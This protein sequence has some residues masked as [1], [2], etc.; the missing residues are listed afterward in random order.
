M[1]FNSLTFALFFAVVLLLH[2]T[3]RNWTA[4]KVV[5]LAASYLFYAAWN[6]PFVALLMLSTVV[7]W[8]AAREMAKAP[9][10]ARRKAWL[11]L[12]LS[13]NLGL[14]GFFKYGPFLLQ[15]FAALVRS[16]GVEYVPP[17]SGII[18]PLGISFYT[19]E[20]LSYTIDVYRRQLKPNC[21]LLDFG[22]F[23]GF[24][25]HLVAGPIVRA[26]DFLPQL[27]RERRVSP[28][29]LGWGLFLMTLGLFEKNV[30]ADAL[31]SDAADA[32][33]GAPG[34]ASQLDTWVGVIAF[35]GQNLLR[36]R[37][38]HDVRDWRRVVPRLLVD[39]QLSRTVCRGWVS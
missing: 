8:F 36:L 18:L 14:L 32:V 28:N 4:K 27:E 12:S 3:L 39:R 16:F 23:V 22:L 10:D 2:H 11:V 26:A 17:E 1:V 31:L 30:V 9:T 5:L 13:A 24:F 19:F 35:A 33:F 21:S 15:N 38:L 25:P 6:P 34:P 29:Q 7:D 37:G 20:T